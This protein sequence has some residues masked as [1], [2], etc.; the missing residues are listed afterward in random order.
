M[1][2]GGVDEGD[3]WR[4]SGAEVMVSGS[5]TIHQS[6]RGE[7]I[8]ALTVKALRVADTTLLKSVNW[9]DRL[10]PGWQR[11]SSQVKG[12]AFQ[13]TLASATDSGGDRPTLSARLDRDP[14][15]YPAGSPAKVE[16]ETEPGV[17]LYLFNLAAD[18]TV[19]LLYPGRLPD[20]PLPARTFV[21]PPP[22]LAR[23]LQ[24]L[25]YPLEDGRFCQESIKVVASRKPLDFSF[26]PV[27]VN[28]MYAGAQG[29]EIKKIRDV[30]ENA[31]DW[32]DVVLSYGVGGECR[33]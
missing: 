10:G 2:G 31:T 20:Q 30:L 19:T 5:Y 16:V 1:Y 3:I 11:L 8:I 7:A 27:P 4:N 22:A 32:R 21:F 23:D 25:F 17:H 13:R 33:E 12:N 6:P 15:C 9:Q 28:Q 29:G 24:L 14:P 18:N 26:L